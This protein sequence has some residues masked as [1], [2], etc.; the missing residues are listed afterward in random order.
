ML[1]VDDDPIV[2]ELLRTSWMA[3]GSNAFAAATA[4]KRWRLEQHGPRIIISDWEMPEMDGLELCR[5]VRSRMGRQHVHFI[6]LTV[7]AS[8]RRF[9]RAFDAGVDDFIAK[10]FT[11]A[12][13]MGRLRAGLRP[14][15]F[16]TSCA[17][18]NQ[19][20]QQLNEQ[21]TQFNDRLETLA[22]TD[23]LT[24]LYNRRQATHRLEEHWAMAERYHRPLA[25]VSWTSITSRRSMTNMPRRRQCGLSRCRG[26]PE[27][28]RAEHRLVC[29]VGGEEFLVILPYQTQQEAEISAQHRCRLA[30]AEQHFE[31]EGNLIR[32][33]DQ[34]RR[35]EPSRGYA[36]VLRP[37]AQRLTSHSIAQRAVAETSSGAREAGALSD[38]RTQV[39]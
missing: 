12:E 33:T 39:A 27:I 10:P 37:A 23:D 4:W 13:L 22:I 2:C 3:G 5:R 38:R 25:V 8:P 36:T 20:S 30:V 7:H 18:Q 16:T 24:G 31:F 6:M 28:V 21:L 26:H 29:R 11:E 35:S 32:A 15:P 34:R 14:L 1:V 19:G 17:R 9:S